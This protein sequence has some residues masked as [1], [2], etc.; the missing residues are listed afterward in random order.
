MN[1]LQASRC[2]SR[3]RLHRERGVISILFALL[4]P[5][6]LGFGAFAIDYPYLLNTRAEMQTVADAAALAG[7]SYLGKGGVPN[8][9]VAVAKAQEALVY[10]KVAGS[11]MA[12]AVIKT[13]YWD[14]SSNRV[15]LQSLPMT[16]K[17]TDVPAIQVSIARSAGQNGDEVKTVF[18]NF[19]GVHSLPISVTAVSARAGPSTVGANVLFP[20][21]ISQCL[22]DLYWNSSSTPPG[23]QL[24]TSGNPKKF[25][26]G[27]KTDPGCLPKSAFPSGAW[28]AFKS[29]D[30]NSNT[31][32]NLV[33]SRLGDSVSVGDQ[34][35]VNPANFSNQLYT[36]VSKCSAKAAPSQQTCRYVTVAVASNGAKS[37]YNDIMGFACIEI[38]DASGGSDKFVTASMSNKCPTPP[39]T[40]IG[41]SFGVTT[42]AKLF[43]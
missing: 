38:L 20:M 25:N 11:T 42:P 24:D 36:D 32:Q 31:L 26:I 19:F 37:G 1:A 23:P 8:W 28:A 18:A 2:W 4:L 21:V 29:G 22:Y 41:P 16:P 6:L 15:G 43:L 30:L 17:K 3:R 9:D 12:Q 5:V 40:G 14:T 39:S 27:S 10:N 33:T 35:F 34:L 7:A 13:G